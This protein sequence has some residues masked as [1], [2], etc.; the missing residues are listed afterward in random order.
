MKILTARMNGLDIDDI[1]VVKRLADLR[2]WAAPRGL[3]NGLD[4]DTIF[5]EENTGDIVAADTDIFERRELVIVCDETHLLAVEL[6][7]FD[8]AIT[9]ISRIQCI[10][11]A[12]TI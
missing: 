6:C 1:V 2:L 11:P 5:A 7:Q 12:D 9:E 3:A 8:A 10:I 4:P